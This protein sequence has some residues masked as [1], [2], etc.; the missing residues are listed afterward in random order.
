MSIQPC[1]I[2]NISME[3]LACLSK[4]DRPVPNPYHTV[5]H[6][7]RPN[8]V[9]EISHTLSR[10]DFNSKSY[11]YRTQKNARDNRSQGDQYNRNQQKSSQG[12]AV[13]NTYEAEQSSYEVKGSKRSCANQNSTTQNIAKSPAVKK[14]MIINL[15]R[16]SMSAPPILV[17]PMLP[18]RLDRC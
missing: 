14:A 11:E 5:Q 18:G 17:V 3:G 9:S 2:S 6:V 16:R 13:A 12:R 4:K 10:S 1:E 15:V 8:K 7:L